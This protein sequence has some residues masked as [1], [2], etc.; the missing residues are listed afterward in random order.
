MSATFCAFWQ[1][2]KKFLKFFNKIL[3]FFVQNSMENWLFSHFLLNISWISH[4]SLKVYTLLEDNTRFIQQFFRF[5]GGTFRRSPSRRCWLASLYNRSC[6]TFR[7]KLLSRL[8]FVSRKNWIFGK[9]ERLPKYV[10]AL[11]STS[12]RHPIFNV[13][14]IDSLIGTYCC[15]SNCLVTVSETNL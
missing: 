7:L 3:R 10:M 5:L 8:Y 14:R 11:A 12:K 15:C 2:L 9:F 1:K 6:K 4:S 13:E